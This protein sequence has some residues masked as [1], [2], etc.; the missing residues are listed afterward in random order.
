MQNLPTASRRATRRRRRGR[1]RAIREGAVRAVS[2]VQADRT[3]PTRSEL[4]PTCAAVRQG[5]IMTTKINPADFPLLTAT[6]EA[7]VP[8]RIME[9]RSRGPLDI[10]SDRQRLVQM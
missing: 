5:E 6:L 3:G 2:V 4:S 1:R 10:D 8:L 9:I 7:A